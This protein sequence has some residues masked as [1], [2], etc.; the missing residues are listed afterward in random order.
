M[1]AP[2]SKAVLASAAALSL[3]AA[4]LPAG[5]FAGEVNNRVNRQQA[6]ID[7]GVRSGQLTQREYDADEN[8]LDRINAAR[9]R[10]LRA[11]GGTL[12]PAER[13]NLNHRLNGNS[14]QIYF[15]K[16]NLAHQPG[17]RTI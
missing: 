5:A 1:T 12:T 11:N 2:F 8:R 6:R 16:H 14:N 9:E 15:T 10:D 7:Q 13:A 4:L 17:A 3:G